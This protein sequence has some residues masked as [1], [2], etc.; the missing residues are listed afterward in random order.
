MCFS[1]PA[2]KLK[3]DL[4][5][6]GYSVSFHYDTECAGSKPAP[7]EHPA[8][9]ELSIPRE[10]ANFFSSRKRRR[11]STRM[12]SGAAPSSGSSRNVSMDQLRAVRRWG[13]SRRWSPK[14]TALPR[15]ARSGDVDSHSG[16]TSA[17]VERFKVGTV[18]FEPM[19]C[20]LTTSPS[21]A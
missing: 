8:E 9:S 13:D 10:L 17:G 12:C 11:N 6:S 2:D 18:C 3:I 1:F 20:P 15:S 16:S 4:L 5:F 14:A 21:S 19:P 7:G